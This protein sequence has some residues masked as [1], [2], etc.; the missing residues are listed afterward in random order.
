[1]RSLSRTS[2]TISAQTAVPKKSIKTF[3]NHYTDQE[4][5]AHCREFGITQHFTGITGQPPPE[6]A[7]SLAEFD[8][9]GQE[10]LACPAGHEPLEQSQSQKGRISFRMATDQCEGCEYQDRCY[11]EEKQQFYSYG[12]WE[13]KLE[14]AKRRARLEDPASQAFLNLRAGA[15]S[16]INEVYHK[17]GKRTRYTGKPTVTNAS[18]ATA[19]GTNLKR[20]SR[21]LNEAAEPSKTTV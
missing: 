4:V 11:V 14:I 1:M 12:F 3:E 18:V 9:D 7:L 17:T 5:E 10:L 13:R 2:S 6:E 16:M 20:V 8:W 21:H 19:I 15:E